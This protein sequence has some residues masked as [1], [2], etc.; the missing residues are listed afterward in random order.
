MMKSYSVILALVLV[1]SLAGGVANAA[2]LHGSQ[3]TNAGQN[4]TVDLT[5]DTTLNTVAI[6]MT[7]PDA[8]WFGVGFEPL[9]H[10]SNPST[11]S[12]IAL[13]G[14]PTPDVQEWT[15]GSFGPVSQLAD[16]LSVDSNTVSA[17]VRTVQL[18][19]LQAGA[20][21]TYPTIPKTMDISWA[22]GSGADF[23]IHAGR[24]ETTLSLV[25]LPQVPE[26]STMLL[27]A[28]GVLFLGC[29]KLSSRRG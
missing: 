9:T 4:M 21:Y 11:Y 23:A 19:G 14:P 8:V 28:A 2:M 22:Y 25:E 18:S 26:P 3:T 7:G 13:G 10:P 20:N 15:L 1:A 24:G 6:T 12:I 16:S 27:A 17:G 5:I 29:C